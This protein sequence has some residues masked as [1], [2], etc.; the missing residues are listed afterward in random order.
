MIEILP[1][2]V[3]WTGQVMPVQ[4]IFVLPWLLLSAQ[5]KTIIFLTVHFFTLFDPIAQQPGQA[6]VLGRLSRCVSAVNAYNV[7]LRDCMETLNR[8]SNNKNQL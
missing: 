5:Y 1:C 4:E 6:D 8:F 2:L 7:Q 3:P